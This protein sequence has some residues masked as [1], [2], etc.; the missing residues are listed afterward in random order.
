MSIHESLP[1]KKLIIGYTFAIFP[2]YDL[3][4]IIN[5]WDLGEMLGHSKHQNSHNY[6]WKYICKLP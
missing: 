4:F 5:L 3:C 1:V 2:L 6:S